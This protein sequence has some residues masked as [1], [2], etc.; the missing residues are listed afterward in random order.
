MR[1]IAP[2]W[3][4]RICFWAA[5]MT[6]GD[7]TRLLE[8]AGSGDRSAFDALYRSVYDELHRMARA[9]MRREKGGH[10]LQPTALVNEAYLRLAPAAANWEGRRHFFGAAAEAMRRILVDHARRRL[11][12]KRGADFERV[13]LT[14]PALE[15]AAPETGLDVLQVDEALAQLRVESPRLADL[16]NLRFFAGLSIED[17]ASALQISPA[18]AK[19]DW[20]FAKAW[21][22]QRFAGGVEAVHE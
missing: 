2:N 21:L 8:A 14:G 3:L 19:R 5:P 1:R 13:T 15:I 9:S 4:I 16:V 12:S 22:H 20:T 11:A 7:V 17:A 10:T 6:N 18:T